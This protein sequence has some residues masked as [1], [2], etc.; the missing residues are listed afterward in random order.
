MP[1]TDCSLDSIVV[2][3]GFGI[4]TGMLKLGHIPMN[5]IL[6]GN[7]GV[8]RCDPERTKNASPGCGERI[9]DRRYSRAGGNDDASRYPSHDNGPARGKIEVTDSQLPA[10]EQVELIVLFPQ[11]DPTRRSIVDVLSEAPGG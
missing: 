10:G 1:G 5:S 2:R 6:R 11:P 7:Q 9:T 8:E 3:R 4:A